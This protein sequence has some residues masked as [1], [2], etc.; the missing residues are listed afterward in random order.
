MGSK[1]L[2]ALLMIYLIAVVPVFFVTGSVVETLSFLAF[3]AVLFYREFGVVIDV[4]SAYLNPLKIVDGR[5]GMSGAWIGSSPIG[6]LL[7]SGFGYFF[8]SINSSDVCCVSSL[9]GFN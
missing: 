6:I 7:L 9:W 5:Y 8:G 3:F 4:S 1:V 2:L